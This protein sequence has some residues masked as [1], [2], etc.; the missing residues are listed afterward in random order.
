MTH[1]ND[2]L[3]ARNLLS[4]AIKS[5]EPTNWGFWGGSHRFSR[6]YTDYKPLMH[7]AE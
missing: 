7:D 1:R 6:L 5:T 4:G 2:N 3:E